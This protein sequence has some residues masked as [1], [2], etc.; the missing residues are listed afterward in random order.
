MFNFHHLP[1][2]HISV[3][4]NIY[5]SVVYFKM[6]NIEIYS[7]YG[8]VKSQFNFSKAPQVTRHIMK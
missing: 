1:S 5:V 6:F 2:F 3:Y 8:T 7:A 4:T